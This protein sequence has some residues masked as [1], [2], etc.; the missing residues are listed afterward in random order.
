M[1]Y[2]WECNI[3][4]EME[5]LLKKH[6]KKIGTAW[7][8]LAFGQ[9]SLLEIPP[10]CLFFMVWKQ[11]DLRFVSLWRRQLRLSPLVHS[12]HKEN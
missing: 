5:D 7:E 6:E 9:Q 12:T 8:E 11:T 4:K 10:G 2:P 1:I 3:T